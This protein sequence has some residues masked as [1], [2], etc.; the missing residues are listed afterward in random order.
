MLASEHKE[1]KSLR[2]GTRTGRLVTRETGQSLCAKVSFAISVPR[3]RFEDFG[4]DGGWVSKS[5]QGSSLRSRV[6]R[7]VQTMN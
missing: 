4:V 7:E 5:A 6:N 3:Q 1:H 2:P